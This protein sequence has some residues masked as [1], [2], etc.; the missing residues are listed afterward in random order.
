MEKVNF[1]FIEPLELQT[2]VR[3]V[4]VNVS[5]LTVAELP[6]FGR[7]LESMPKLV[8][9]ISAALADADAD[10]DAV[11]LAVGIS[12]VI[13][14]AQSIIEAVSVAARQPV[15]WVSTLRPDEL[16]ALATLAVRVNADFFLRALPGMQRWI[17]ASAAVFS[18][19]PTSALSTGPMP[20]AS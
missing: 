18:A 19:A 20:S 11:V 15:D 6:R 9:S 2:V 17:E 10:F 5:P 13:D 14:H 12:A 16:V 7:A 3:G 8:A 4:E 1:E